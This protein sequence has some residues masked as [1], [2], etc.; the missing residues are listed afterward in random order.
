[1]NIHAEY[2]FEEYVN[3]RGG[4]IIPVNTA[5]AFPG[6]DSA[7]AFDFSSVT[8]KQAFGNSIT[9]TVG[10]TKKGYQITA[11][12]KGENDICNLSLS[13]GSEGNASLTI[14]SNSRSTMSYSEDISKVEGAE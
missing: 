1:L 7:N 13:V 6:I 12:V 11:V 2:N 8:L 9:I 3:L 4:T 10:K 14:S 5:L